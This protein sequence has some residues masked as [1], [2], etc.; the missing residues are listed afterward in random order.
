M[1]PRQDTNA[2][3]LYIPLVAMTTYVMMAAM[4]AV[5]HQHFSPTSLYSLVGVRPFIGCCMTC[6]CCLTALSMS[7]VRGWS[8][9]PDHCCTL[10][11]M[12]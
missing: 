8:A 12:P 2:P 5:R 7:C 9:S 6:V 1:P 10:D 11:D 4:V 3:D